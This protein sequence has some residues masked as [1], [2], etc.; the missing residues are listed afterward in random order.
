[1]VLPWRPTPCFLALGSWKRCFP[2]KRITRSPLCGLLQRPD[3]VP[4]GEAERSKQ[5][6]GQRAH[7]VKATHSP[8]LLEA[9]PQRFEDLPH[10]LRLGVRAN[11]PLPQCAVHL[12]GFGR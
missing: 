10:L 2:S 11:R 8:S 6:K 5:A 4:Q 3:H 9:S 1:M 7:C 12:G